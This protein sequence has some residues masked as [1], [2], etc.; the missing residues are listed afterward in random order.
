MT[1][2]TPEFFFESP[3]KCADGGGGSFRPSKEEAIRFWETG[4]RSKLT[5]DQKKRRRPGHRSRVAASGCGK[6]F[7]RG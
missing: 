5:R 7:E 2:R 1:R 4:P 3:L 6:I